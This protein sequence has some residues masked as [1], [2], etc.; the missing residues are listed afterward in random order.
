M[1]VLHDSGLFQSQT[2]PECSQGSPSTFASLPD[3]LSI[4][5]VPLGKT[6]DTKWILVTSHCRPRSARPAM[7]CLLGLSCHGAKPT[8]GNISQDRHW[9]LNGVSGSTMEVLGW[10][11]C[12]CINMNP[13]ILE[14]I[15]VNAPMPWKLPCSTSCLI[16]HPSQA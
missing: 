9:L 15:F 6:V 4:A 5:C 11:I 8:I 1:G 12:I 16:Q 7:C 13:A 10:I 2:A 14:S 3:A